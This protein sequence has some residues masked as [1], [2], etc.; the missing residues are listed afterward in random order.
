MS[1]LSLSVKCQEQK[2]RAVEIA[3]ASIRKNKK[4]LTVDSP[5]CV[6]GDDEMTAAGGS[7]GGGAFLLSSQC[8]P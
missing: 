5:E 3:F 7:S 4:P 6:G 2:Y 1:G 8:L